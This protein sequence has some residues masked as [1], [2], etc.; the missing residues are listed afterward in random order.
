[1]AK[2]PVSKLPPVAVADYVRCARD[3]AVIE[4][5]C[6]DYRAGATCDRREDDEDRGRVAEEI[7]GH[8]PPKLSAR[9]VPLGAHERKR[10]CRQLRRQQDERE[11]CRKCEGARSHEG[12]V[13]LRRSKS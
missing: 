1:M 5:M 12:M 4:A 10:R 11:R 2:T 9:C 6:E 8:D 13:I 3:P 7:R